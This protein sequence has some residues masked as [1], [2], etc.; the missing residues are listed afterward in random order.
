MGASQHL[1][2]SDIEV[3]DPPDFPD[4]DR[5]LGEAA[6][7]KLIDSY[8]ELG[9][10]GQFHV[11]EVVDAGDEVVVIWRARVRTPHGGGFPLEGTIVHVLLFEDG[12]V[13]RIRQYLSRAEALEAAGLRE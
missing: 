11:Q 7:R 13:C 5:Y 10:D 6:V 9:W 3:F 1:R 2:H 12:K 4:A 8:R